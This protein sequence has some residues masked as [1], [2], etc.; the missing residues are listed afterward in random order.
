MADSVTLAYGEHPDQ[1]AR[2]R[3]AP[4]GRRGIAVLVHG[5]YWRERLTAEL[6]N[7]LADDLSRR[8][9][10]TV[11]V[12]YR[13][14]PRAVWPTPLDDVRAACTVAAEWAQAEAIYGP[15][16]GIGHSVGG[17]LALLAGAPL[18]GVVAL[19]PVTNAVLT[20][21]HGLGEG[22]AQEY[23]RATPEQAP[24][25]YADA[26]PIARL[27]VGRPTLIAHG[28]DDDRV[29]VQHSLDYLR[30]SLEA[31]DA[32]SGEF[33]PRLSHLEAIDPRA[34]HWPAVLSW[35]ARQDVPSSTTVA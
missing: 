24:E 7:P 8:G 18:D 14:G 5:G 17:Q 31:G 27:P 2:C 22:A 28:G 11:N 34:E 10:A 33:L 9:W 15:M 3:V 29:P 21:A 19:A 32:I 6:M 30:A 16:I 20:H 25:R 26:S 4:E 1:Q 13:R 35:M 12:E 23:F